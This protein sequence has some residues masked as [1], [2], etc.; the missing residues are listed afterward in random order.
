MSNE[1]LGPEGELWS[2]VAPA[3]LTMRDFSDAVL[4]AYLEDVGETATTS[5]GGY[6]LEGVAAQL[7]DRVDG[8]YFTILGLPMTPL[9]GALRQ[10]GALEV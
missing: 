7:F 3:R 8:D 6:F 9:L 2:H 4:D 5:V 1:L 10:A